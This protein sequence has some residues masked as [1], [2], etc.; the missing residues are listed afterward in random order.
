MAVYASRPEEGGNAGSALSS[1]VGLWKRIE[2]DHQ[3]IIWTVCP[4]VYEYASLLEDGGNAG[5]SHYPVLDLPFRAKLSC[6]AWNTYLKTHLLAADY[7]GI[8][9]LVDASAGTEVSW[10]SSLDRAGVR[11]RCRSPPDL[12]LP[13]L[14]VVSLA[15]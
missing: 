5:G 13:G 12:L 9:T 3:N 1:A 10:S 2:Q 11:M 14:V 7:A 15:R 4:Q 8:A 6:V